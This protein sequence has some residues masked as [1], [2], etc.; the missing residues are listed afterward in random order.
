MNLMMVC[1]KAELLFSNVLNMSITGSI[2][3]LVVLLTR[4][5]L[6]RA[7]KVFSYALWAVVLFRLLCPVTVMSPFSLFG[8]LNVERVSDAIEQ[9]REQDDGWKGQNTDSETVKLPAENIGGEVGINAGENMESS[10]DWKSEASAIIAVVWLL[11]VSAMGCY[12][13]VTLIRLRRK[14]SDAVKL[15]DNIYLSDH[16]NSAFVIG[17]LRT[18]IYLPSGLSEHEREYILLHEQHHIRRGD[19]IIKLLAFV[20]LCVHWFN[21]LVWLAFVLAGKDME[22][23]CDESVIRTLGEAV[24][25]DYSASLLSLATGHRIIAGTP[26]AFGEGNPKDR[27]RNLA[28]WK[29]PARG[30]IV[31]AVLLCTVLMVCLFTDP[32]RSLSQI[33][34]NGIN[35]VL[36]EETVTELPDV[37][38]EMGVLESVLHGTSKDPEKDFSGTNLD[39]K[40]P[41]CMI[42][43]EFGVTDVIYLEDYSGYYL[44]F[45][46][47]LASP[48]HCTWVME[49]IVFNF[50]SSYPY[51]KELAPGYS[52]R[53]DGELC[54]MYGDTGIIEGRFESFAL[55][56]KKFDSFFDWSSDK[57]VWTNGE[58]LAAMLRRNNAHAWK[59]DVPST[60]YMGDQP[61]YY[62]LQQKNGDVYL[63]HGYYDPQGPNDSFAD[64]TYIDWMIRLEIR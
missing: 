47:E 36:Q 17:Q 4:V 35:Y 37:C 2:V 52:I 53:Y 59:L 58:N 49:E 50:N 41:G 25:A 1:E 5:M 34:I 46:S 26:L 19:H 48:F 56:E 63:A 21:P 39:E 8:V 6:K 24:R 44:V 33:K 22:M 31:S 30:L 9:M 60:R 18:R 12:S 32:K 27:I 57:G 38:Y 13:V 29:Q 16:I 40:Y 62:L 54:I 7:P 28:R 10:S 3:I 43:Q 55:S 20:A 23:S 45:A 11:G 61:F 15:E 51:P 14:L 64:D 42:Y